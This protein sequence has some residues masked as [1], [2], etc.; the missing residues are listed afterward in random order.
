MK[1]KF[2]LIFLTTIF[3]IFQNSTGTKEHS[4]LN[5][6][7]EQSLIATIWMC[8][9][10]IFKLTLSDISWKYTQI[11]SSEDCAKDCFKDEWTL[12]LCWLCAQRK[13]E[14]T[15]HGVF[16][17]FS[18]IL[19]ESILK[20]YCHTKAGQ[21]NHWQMGLIDYPI[22]QV[23]QKAIVRF[24]FLAY[25]CNLLIKQT[26]KTMSN[27]EKTLWRSRELQKFNWLCWTPILSWSE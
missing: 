24:K 2:G 5:Q 8:F 3:Y 15:D 26:W 12:A 27:I 19:D 10:L 18:C 1:T 7:Y 17:E 14:L 13:N 16:L 4:L 23:A 9:L 21:N 6:C 20:I 25:F 22:L 11:V